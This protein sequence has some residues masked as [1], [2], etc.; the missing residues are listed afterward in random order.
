MYQVE[1]RKATAEQD[2]LAIHFETFHINEIFLAEK[3]VSRPDISI[4]FHFK[5]TPLIL[6]EANVKLEPFFVAPI[7]SQSLVMSFY[8]SMD[9]FI[10]TCKPTVFSRIFG[11]NLSLISELSINL[12]HA[13]FYP[14]WNDLSALETIGERIDYFSKFINKIQNTAYVPDPVDQL[15]DKI[16]EKGTTTLLKDIMYDFYVCKRTLERN[17]IRRTGVSPK[18][19]MRIVRLDY[20]LTKIS[21]GN[22]IDYQDM[23][24]DGK[25][26]DQSHLINDFKSIVGETPGSFLK[27]NL[28]LTKMFSG[29]VNRNV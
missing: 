27:R 15:Y 7:I 24:F 22:A 23:V 3:F 17:F 6:S 11:I 9:S 29:R 28:Q 19:L 1:Y 5:D 25:Y 12:P 18:T 21:D 10:V 20:L 4:I 8:G 16:I 26:F 2:W 13:I 14:V